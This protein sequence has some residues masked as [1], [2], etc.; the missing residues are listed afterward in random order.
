GG[1]SLA[2]RALPQKGPPWRDAD[3]HSRL[4]AAQAGCAVSERG[5]EEEEG[6]PAAD[7]PARRKDLK[8]AK[9]AK[10]AK[11]RAEVLAEH[12][13]RAAELRASRGKAAA[14]PAATA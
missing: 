9:E 11:E 5:D 8:K 3:H 7:A 12:T 10:E 1:S 13:K 2:V 6:R 14:T 4:F